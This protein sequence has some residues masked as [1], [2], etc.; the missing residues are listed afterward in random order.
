MDVLQ[1]LNKFILAYIL[2]ARRLGCFTRSLGTS[3]GSVDFYVWVTNHL[4]LLPIGQMIVP[5]FQLS[6]PSTL[7]I[8]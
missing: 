3:F 4:I 1:R 8:A 5:N 7:K 6:P 2:K